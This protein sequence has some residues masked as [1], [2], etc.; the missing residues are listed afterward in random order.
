MEKKTKGAARKTEI[1]KRVEFGIQGQRTFRWGGSGQPCLVLLRGQL[2]PE[3]GLLDWSPWNSMETIIGE[4]G[5]IRG[6]YQEILTSLAWVENEWK[7]KEI[8]HM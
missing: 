4:F 3:T 6:V 5:L 1:H 2:G 7:S 8:E